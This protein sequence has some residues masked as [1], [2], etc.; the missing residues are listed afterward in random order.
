[1]SE[2]VNLMY[3][4]LLD[5]KISLISPLTVDITDVYASLLASKHKQTTKKTYESC[6]NQFARYLI[7]KVV[8]KGK[9]GTKVN[10]RP[11][12]EEYL[13]LDRKVAISLFAEY[14]NALIAAGYLPNSINIK[15]AAVKSLVKF[16]LAFEVCSFSLDAVKS[17][18]AEVYRD[19]KGT[20]VDNI[21]KLLALPD[22]STP[23]GKRD[24]ALLRCLWDLGLRRAEAAALSWGDFDSNEGTLMVMG[25]GRISKVK[26]PLAP[27]TV[28]ALTALKKG[29]DNSPIFTSFDRRGV[30][31]RLTVKG[32][33][34]LVRE[35]S[36][37]VEGG[38]ILS[39]HKIRHSA[40][41]AVLDASNG[42]VRLAQ[43]LSRHKNTDTLLKYDDNRKQEHQ[44]AVNLLAGLV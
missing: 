25:K 23:K 2:T 34:K 41:T 1:M 29:A 32:I 10:A 4:E 14:Q 33:Y 18:P 30:G 21:S 3:S 24:Y 22:T 39:P 40:I 11:V 35:Y 28:Q 13:Q 26:I 36:S 5:T 15:L 6:L 9:G 17:L 42:N 20:S 27:K 37:K 12:L 19:T 38:K 44:K 7:S 43:N 31:K 8:I 16:A